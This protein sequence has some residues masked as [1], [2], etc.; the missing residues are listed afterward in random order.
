MKIIT[1]ST[2]ALLGIQSK[3]GV[4]TMPSIL[5]SDSVRSS[6]YSLQQTN[7]LLST[8]QNRLATG[9]KVNSAN[10]NPTVF[11]TASALSN[12]AADLNSVF[13]GITAA[14]K[15]LKSTNDSISSLTNL[16]NSAA[17]TARNALAS[18]GTTAR[19]TG[20]V[21][22]LT[23]ANSFAVAATKTFTV[24]DGAT[25]ATVTSAGALTVQQVLDGVNNTAG[26]KVRASLTADGKLQLE[27]NST[28]T[29]TV[30]GTATAPELA[31]FGLTAGVTAAGTLNTSRSAAA[32]QFDSIR[33][34]IDQLATDANFN[35]TNLL[36]GGSLKI[37]FNEKSTSSL[38]VAGVTDTSAG[39]GIVASAGTFQT[40]KDI[41]DALT[42]L[43]NSLN[44]L[45]SQ[46]SVFS[47]HADIVT[48][49]QDF[50]KSLI[51]ALNSASDSLTAADTNEEGANLLALQTR[52]SLSTTALT[53][54]A[55][56]GQSVLQ[57][58]R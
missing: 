54:A 34:Q 25:T 22:G 3:T 7:A 35:G 14:S 24:S 45:R 2:R 4:I 21:S 40:D 27:A 1:R 23:G 36:N 50:T 49:R 29:I 44:T 6:L 55:Q 39:L 32:I 47:T 15:V 5:L 53:L 38:N 20:S 42:N 51:S 41:N 13:D 10:D 18:T 52:Q 58:F 46:A 26:L 28:N 11:F 48:T 57:L 31:Q 19:T 12:R 37:N 8:T 33:S 17:S 43:T 16:V 30:G 56:A 9:R